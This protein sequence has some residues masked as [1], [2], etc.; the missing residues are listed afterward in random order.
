MLGCHGHPAY[1]APS[2]EA[3]KVPQFDW[4]HCPFDLGNEH[5]RV[6]NDLRAMAKVMPLSHFPHGYAAWVATCLPQ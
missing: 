6:L 4:S 1:H 5:L 2:D 3:R